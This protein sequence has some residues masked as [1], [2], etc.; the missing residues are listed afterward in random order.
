MNTQLNLFSNY[1]R[2]TLPYVFLT[3][4][5][6]SCKKDKPVVITDLTFPIDTYYVPFGGEIYISINQGNNKYVL[7]VADEAIIRPQ[8]PLDHWP[9][10]AFYVSGLKKGSTE[11]TVTDEIS[12]QKKTL[13]IHVVD[14]FLVMRIGG[15]VPGLM[16]DQR[17]P[18]ATQVAIR[19]EAKSFGLFSPNEVLILQNNAGQQFYLFDNK[20]NMNILKTLDASDIKYSGTYEFDTTQDSSPFDEGEIRQLTLYPDDG[21]ESI[22]LPIRAN[23]QYSAQT[24]T[25]FIENTNTPLGENQPI[26]YFRQKIRFYT[27]LTDHFK[28]D[29]PDYLQYVMVSHT[30]ELWW[31]YH[32]YGLKIGDDIFK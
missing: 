32:N 26:D 21:E 22:I 27:D 1:L 9:A 15:P 19:K 25:D 20:G 7:D 8:A 24:L 31:N 18:N 14:P 30:A 28:P 6:L 5:A 2:I 12:G 3:L 10:G 11:L 17:M 16:A 13:L 23:N 4:F 29:Y